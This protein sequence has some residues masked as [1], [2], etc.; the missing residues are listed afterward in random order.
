MIGVIIAFAAMLMTLAL[1]GKLEWT[2][3]GL[4]WT[5][6]WFAIPAFLTIFVYAPFSLWKERQAA[7]AHR[8]ARAKGKT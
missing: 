8:D 3:A 1:G 4:I 2:P 6:V 5:A 7:E